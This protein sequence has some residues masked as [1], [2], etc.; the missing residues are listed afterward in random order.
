MSISLLTIIKEM[1]V[2]ETD[3][4]GSIATKVGLLPALEALWLDNNHQL[5]GTIPTEIGRL[6]GLRWLA[7]AVA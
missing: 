6:S 1:E 4:V 7:L 3:V 5:T 2:S